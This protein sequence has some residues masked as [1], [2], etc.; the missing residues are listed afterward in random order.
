MIKFLSKTLK[1][2]D[3]ITTLSKIGFSGYSTV[4]DVPLTSLFHI[5][6]YGLQLMSSLCLIGSHVM[7]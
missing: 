5:L 2:I 4:S 7:K 6:F 3:D 1:Y